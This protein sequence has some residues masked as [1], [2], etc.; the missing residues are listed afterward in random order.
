MSKALLDEIAA[1]IQRRFGVS[2]GSGP[3]GRGWFAREFRDDDGDYFEALAGPF[4]TEHE[5]ELAARHHQAR[6]VLRAV[7]EA[8]IQGAAA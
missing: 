7:E 1:L 8:Q 2:H 6:L 4:E 5:A 3:R